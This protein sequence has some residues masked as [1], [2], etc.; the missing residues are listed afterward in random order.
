MSTR[1]M[2]CMKL[3]DDN[4]KSIYCHSDGY[5]EYNGAMLI[6]YYKDRKKGLVCIDELRRQIRIEMY[7]AE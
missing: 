2:I 3:K 6:D 4:Y 1:S 7:G 5:L